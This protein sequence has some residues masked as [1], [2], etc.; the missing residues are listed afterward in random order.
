MRLGL[1]KC[2]IVE[3]SIVIIIINTHIAAPFAGYN[4]GGWIEL[5]GDGEGTEGGQR[6]HSSKQ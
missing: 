6:S 4:R 2:L 5:S 3:V 1:L